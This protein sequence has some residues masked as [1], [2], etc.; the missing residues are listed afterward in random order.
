MRCRLD[1]ASPGR[2]HRRDSPF[3]SGTRATPQRHRPRRGDTIV[4][5]VASRPGGAYALAELQ[6][7]GVTDADVGA[8]DVAGSSCSSGVGRRP[9]RHPAAS[10]CGSASSL[11]FAR[12]PSGLGC[13]DWPCGQNPGR[14]PAI[15]RRARARETQEPRRT[16]FDLRGQLSLCRPVGVV[17]RRQQEPPAGVVV[18]RDAPRGVRPSSNTIVDT[19]C[20]RAWGASGR[21]VAGRART[22]RLPPG[23]RLAVTFRNPC[24]TPPAGQDANSP[25]AKQARQP[26]DTA[27][28]ARAPHT[29]SRQTAS[30]HAPT[31]PAPPA[32]RQPRPQ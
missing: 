12:A 1:R 10:S 27:D 31:T 30:T 13:R 11:N 8:G 29:G 20:P 28:T 16:G 17:R 15:S 7:A 21:Q 22:L 6:D 14:K 24:A 4:R 26:L 3:C 25:R 32:A 18:E 5:T 2:P 19:E 9:D 23:A